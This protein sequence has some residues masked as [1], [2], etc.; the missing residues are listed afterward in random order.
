MS[1]YIEIN[2][3][4]NEVVGLHVDPDTVPNAGDGFKMIELGNPPTEG[5]IAHQE[6]DDA[7]QQIIDTP[8]STSVKMKHKLNQ[9]DWLVIRHRDQLDGV[10]IQTSISDAEYQQLI[11]DR[12]SWRE[13]VVGLGN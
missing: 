11:A 10:G 8:M 6:W 7:S 9:S 13:S 3:I 4:T 12:Q 2:N 1:T 5:F